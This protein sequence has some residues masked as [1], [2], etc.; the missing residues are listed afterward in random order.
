MRSNA[1]VILGKLSHSG[2][3]HRLLSDRIP[4]RAYFCVW[5]GIRCHWPVDGAD[6]RV[7]ISLRVLVKFNLS[8]IRL[9]SNIKTSFL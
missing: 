7:V 5:D 1:R 8:E 2:I 3:T 6:V 4:L 9:E